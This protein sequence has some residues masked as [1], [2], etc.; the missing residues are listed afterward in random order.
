MTEQT[1]KTKKRMK[2]KVV[3]DKMD[4]TVV[5]LV[6]RLVKHPKLGKYIKQSKRY[7]A[8]D[9]GNTRTVGEYVTIEECVPVS[10]DKHFKVIND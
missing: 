5:V 3:S 2:G 7:K 1:T 8:H 6:D 4:K 9:E 10:K